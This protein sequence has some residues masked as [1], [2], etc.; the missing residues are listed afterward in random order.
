MKYH[1]SLQSLR[2][3]KIIGSKYSMKIGGFFDFLVKY[4]YPDMSPLLD[5]HLE[6]LFKSIYRYYLRYENFL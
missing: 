4:M 1:F 5:I 3:F 6:M 2:D